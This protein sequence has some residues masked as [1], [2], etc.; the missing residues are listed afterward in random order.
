MNGTWILLI[1]ELFSKF[2]K[3]FTTIVL[4]LNL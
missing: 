2:I 1:I 4:E 3:G